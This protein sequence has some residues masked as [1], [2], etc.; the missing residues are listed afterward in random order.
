MFTMEQ[1]MALQIYLNNLLL[2]K[3]AYDYGIDVKTVLKKTSI[4]PT[5]W[6]MDDTSL[7]TFYQ[8]SKHTFDAVQF[9]APR[10]G[11]D[12]V[13]YWVELAGEADRNLDSCYVWVILDT[14]LTNAERDEI[15]STENFG[16]DVQV[17]PIDDGVV[18][19][20]DEDYGQCDWATVYEYLVII[21][22]KNKQES[23]VNKKMECEQY[24]VAV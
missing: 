18:F 2:V 9:F 16:A 12:D 19:I 8:L 1:L 11:D 6:G 21:H 22:M 3:L 14:Y 5:P 17:R 13:F 15:F 20:I 4:V 24:E 10:E 7:E 23:V